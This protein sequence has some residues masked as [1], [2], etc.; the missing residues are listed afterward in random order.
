MQ[1]REY[2]IDGNRFSD[3]QGFFDQISEN[4]I[5]GAEWGRNL[6]AFND[7][8]RGG[9]GT[10]DEGFVLIWRNSEE[11][12]RRLGYTETVKQLERRLE[13]CH[14]TNRE[15]VTNDLQKA[16]RNKGSTV[17][18]WLVEI[19]EVHCKGGEE[20]EDAVELRLA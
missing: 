18:D 4:L 13:R 16:Q 6:D 3:L 10:P 12:K 14:P 9:F 1:K 2:E 11:S 7:I 5:L 20:E 19:I 8:L 17:F 15:D